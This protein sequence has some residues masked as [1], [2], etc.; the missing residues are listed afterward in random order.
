MKMQKATP[1]VLNQQPLCHITRTIKDEEWL[2]KRD[3][4]FKT[5]QQ[6]YP[7][8]PPL[9]SINFDSVML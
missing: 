7:R 3:D 9:T 6:S 2:E 5:K 1:D 4:S 8:W